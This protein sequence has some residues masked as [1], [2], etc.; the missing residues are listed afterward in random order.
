MM[1]DVFSY[2]WKGD[3]DIRTWGWGHDT[4]VRDLL[5]FVGLLKFSV[6]NSEI[7]AASF[8]VYVR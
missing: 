4:L 7:M 8:S 1:C 2:G 3:T 6:R 5:K